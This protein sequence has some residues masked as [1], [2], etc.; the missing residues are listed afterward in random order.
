VFVL[1]VSNESPVAT[2]VTIHEETDRMVF[3]LGG[4]SG[5][6]ELDDGRLIRVIGQLVQNCL[7]AFSV[8]SD[9]TD[10]SVSGG[11]EILECLVVLVVCSLLA[12]LV[13]EHRNF[14]VKKRMDFV[15]TSL[16]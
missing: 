6:G 14:S 12:R 15:P 4:T 9:V 10:D 13:C 3:I 8:L 5:G 16:T 7:D 11:D 1:D 2:M